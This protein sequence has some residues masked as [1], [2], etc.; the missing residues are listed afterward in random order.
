MSHRLYAGGFSK[1][2][3]AWDV[4]F[5]GANAPPVAAPISTLR[6]PVGRGN[7]GAINALAISPT[8]ELL[9]IGGDSARGTGDITFFDT[10]TNE[11]V[12][13]FPGFVH[14]K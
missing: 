13:T 7:L 9:V 2:V 4:G 8:E 11:L 10:D 6:W 12:Q 3:H 1:V 14:H 5:N